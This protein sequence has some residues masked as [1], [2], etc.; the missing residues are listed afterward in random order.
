MA[1]TKS[2]YCSFDDMLVRARE[3]GL[4][5]WRKI[6]DHTR[7]NIEPDQVWDDTKEF[8]D[9]ERRDLN[10]WPSYYH[11]DYWEEQPYCLR[12]FIEKDALAQVASSVALEYKVTTIPG[13]GYNSFAQL[14]GLADELQKIDKSIII[15]YFGDF[16]PTGLDID[17]S[18]GKR[19]SSYSDRDIKLVRM[20]LTE[21][22]IQGLPSNPTKK[23]D[24]RTESY[25]Q[26]YGECCWE[27]DALPPD[28]LKDRVR[29]SIKAYIDEV[30]W[31]KDIK[32]ENDG[33]LHI[34]EVAQ[35]IGA[36]WDSEVLEDEDDD[37]D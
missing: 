14:M 26:K 9:A 20:A 33:R 11:V 8:L 28:V 34:N 6:A 37:N 31:Q 32:R 25:S 19:L 35:K 36:F 30:Q 27:L 24:P 2:M 3:E 1:N 13:R 10:R 29:T 23:T 17:R 16:D 5:D 15:L 4:V 18:A 21:A 22:D 7:Q 12:V